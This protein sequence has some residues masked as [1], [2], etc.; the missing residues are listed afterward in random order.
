VLKKLLVWGGVLIVA[1]SLAA[2]AFA[3]TTL[4]LNEKWG[5]EQWLINQFGVNGDISPFCQTIGQDP[6]ERA[7]WLTQFPNLAK[8]CNFSPA[9]GGG[10][11]DG[12]SVSEPNS[13]DQT[14]ESSGIPRANDGSS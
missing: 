3:Q 13:A 4:D 1:A 8:V 12:G 10:G 9:T 2:P 6:T 7:K 5:S 14:P 11:G